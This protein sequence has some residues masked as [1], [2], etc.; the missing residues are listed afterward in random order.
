MKQSTM[1]SEDSFQV[2]APAKINLHLEVLG[3]RPDGFHELAMVMQTIDLFDCITIQ[4]RSDSEIVITSTDRNLSMGDD[5]LIM[6]A[7]KL[8]RRE[9]G[10]SDLG[11]SIH[12][13][14]N[15]P[16]GAGLA[17]GSSDGAATL[18]G[19]NLLWGINFPI[20]SLE[21]M[22]AELGSDV[23]FCVSGGLQLCFGRG[24]ILEPLNNSLED[25]AIVL[26]KDPSKEVS[27]PWAYSRYKEINSKNYLENEMEFENRRELLR[28]SHWLNPIKALSAPPLRNDLQD[29][30][31]PV[32]PEVQNGLKF[33]SSLKGVQSIAMSGSGPSCFGLFE[34]YKTA[35]NSL[36]E[37]N[38]TLDEYGLKA[39]CCTF[40]S[41]NLI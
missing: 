28:N 16:I 10:K 22:S 9:S 38:R 13:V 4:D 39:W 5:N 8:L 27:T 30:V 36:D 21:R 33:L 40:Q 24:E 1:K 25:F 11:A 29:V 7:A 26:V 31:A 34:D 23:P 17:G 20:E 6:R 18:R 32:I 14:K 41:K 12:L 35:K 37:K 3:L 2:I 15:I 19:L